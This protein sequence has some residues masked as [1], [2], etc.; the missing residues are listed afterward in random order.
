M[1]QVIRSSVSVEATFHE[2][3]GEYKFMVDICLIT[4]TAA[5]PSEKLNFELEVALVSS[6]SWVTA[7]NHV[8]MWAGGTACCYNRARHSLF[9]FLIKADSLWLKLIPGLWKV[10]PTM[11]R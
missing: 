7:P 11:P 2:D 9:S 4:K 10:V 6:C 8:C 5:A 3:I 1:K